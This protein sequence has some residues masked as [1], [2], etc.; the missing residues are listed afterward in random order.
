MGS[1]NAIRRGNTLIDKRT[2]KK[3]LPAIAAKSTDDRPI[4]VP[5][6]FL[7][8]GNEHLKALYDYVVDDAKLYGRYSPSYAFA[9]EQLVRTV[10][11]LQTDWPLLQEEGSV[12]PIYS[13]KTGEPIGTQINPR[14]KIVAALQRNLVTLLGQLG[15][16]PRAVQYLMVTPGNPSGEGLPDDESM[17][18]SRSPRANAVVLFR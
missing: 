2:R 6:D 3:L 5:P 1:P 16:S 12:T 11:Q 7:L 13:M 10:L 14:A 8:P 9:Y 18:K 15:L 17:A 4:M